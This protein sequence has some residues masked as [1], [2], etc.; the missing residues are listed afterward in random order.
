MLLTLF[1]LYSLLVRFSHFRIS[2]L[3]KLRQN[4]LDP[5]SGAYSAQKTLFLLY[6]LIYFDESWGVYLGFLSRK[7]HGSFRTCF[8]SQYRKFG[9]EGWFA[10][11]IDH[12]KFWDFD[13]SNFPG[14]L[15]RVCSVVNKAWELIVEVK[16][17]KSLL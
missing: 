16:L 13:V 10:S 5:F 17:L 4:R 7:A 3:R 15:E 1:F 12:A 14:Y 11:V 9:K 6:F 2:V 8:R